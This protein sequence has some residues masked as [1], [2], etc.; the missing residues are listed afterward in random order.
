MGCAVASSGDIARIKGSCS[1][2]SSCNLRRMYFC[3]SVSAVEFMRQ[4]YHRACQLSGHK[5]VFTHAAMPLC[6]ALP[7]VLLSL[8]CRSI[9]PVIRV[10]ASS[11][12]QRRCPRT[13]SQPTPSHCPQLA[14]LVHPVPEQAGHSSQS[15]SCIVLPFVPAHRF[16]PTILPHFPLIRVALYDGA[17]QFVHLATGFGLWFREF[18]STA[19]S[20][21]V[22][23]SAP[24]TAYALCLTFNQ[25]CSA[26][27][28]GITMRPGLLPCSFAQ[29]IS[30]KTSSAISWPTGTVLASE[31]ILSA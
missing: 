25:V 8:P 1:L 14:E 16:P 18:V 3:L 19:S 26:D 12:R 21:Y 6:L 5:A 7:D 20:A 29:P 27:R 15:V 31:Y 11:G 23:P 24:R 9:L 17:P 22:S 10:P 4:F 30:S 2:F 13:N 28:L